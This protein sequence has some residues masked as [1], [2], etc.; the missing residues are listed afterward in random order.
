MRIIDWFLNYFIAFSPKARTAFKRPVISASPK[1]NS[2]LKTS[3]QVLIS[4]LE[5][6]SVSFP[7]L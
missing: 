6:H 2:I 5:Q 1:S 7:T 4:S 3:L